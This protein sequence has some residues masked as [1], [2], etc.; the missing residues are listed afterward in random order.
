MKNFSHWI[1][2]FL[3]GIF[4][5]ILVHLFFLD[6]ESNKGSDFENFYPAQESEF[7]IRRYEFTD[8]ELED[9]FKLTDWDLKKALLQNHAE[10][11]SLNEYKPFF[12]KLRT[13]YFSVSRSEWPIEENLNVLR[14]S[15]GIW[16]KR[17]FDSAKDYLLN[18]KDLD[19]ETLRYDSRIYQRP[20]RSYLKETL[21]PSM[22]VEWLKTDKDAC[23]EFLKMD[24][25]HSRNE[26]ANY[27]VDHF[28]REYPKETFDILM[29]R[30]DMYESIRSLK[31]QD[32]LKEFYMQMPSVA[33]ETVLN[34]KPG[35][36]E[37]TLLSLLDI[38]A[39]TDPLQTINIIREQNDPQK[40]KILYEISKKMGE[41]DALSAVEV[42]AQGDFS[43]NEK[44][45]I[46]EGLADMMNLEQIQH[47][48]ETEF[49]TEEDTLSLLRAVFV[50]SKWTTEGYIREQQYPYIEENK[51]ETFF[52]WLTLLSE[53]ERKHALKN[54][55]I[56]RHFQN[57]AIQITAYESLHDESLLQSFIS[58]LSYN[59][60]KRAIHYYANHVTDK[61]FS[62]MENIYSL[63]RGNIEGLAESIDHAQ[64][65]EWLEM[66]N[67]VGASS[68]GGF[69]IKNPLNVTSLLQRAKDEDAAKMA[70]KRLLGSMS[71]HN[72]EQY[73]DV[74]RVT[75][76]V[77][78]I[79]ETADESM[80]YMIGFSE[81]YTLDMIDSFHDRPDIQD[82]LRK[83][84]ADV[85]LNTNPQKSLEMLLLLEPGEK[86]N[87]KI[88]QALDQFMQMKP[89]EAKNWCRDNNIKYETND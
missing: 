88:K 12:D 16:L 11:L 5:G 60:P 84:Y 83:K 82:I 20:Y 51:S 86:T 39:T 64:V 28:K 57:P 71:V 35:I 32:A 27:F 61:K 6:G 37:G 17:D 1:V 21:A 77:S 29:E 19:T 48:I 70:Y 3:L 36:R 81:D 50:D 7:F 14:L 85:F 55:A 31:Y 72:I 67:A 63:M 18:T 33:L 24:A 52:S 26:W 74:L 58:A 9:I 66:L 8:L 59:D 78:W 46:Y 22:F 4:G 40:D 44:R 69:P 87:Q 53:D 56:T 23:L 62:D 65:K 73:A 45:I 89:E 13:Q 41:A 68:M 49:L 43:E 38:M 54:I 30:P 2:I 42:I 15:Y 10:G 79:D 75:D 76:D 80:K 34:L 25:L 47:I